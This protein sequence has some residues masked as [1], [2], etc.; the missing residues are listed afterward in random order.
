[1]T[2]LLNVKDLRAYYGQVQA[3][4]GLSFS[5]NEGSLTTLLGA[6][7]AGK[8]TTLRAICNMVRSTGA[9]EFEGKPLNNKSTESIVRFGIAHVPQ[10]RGTF[11]NMT[12][13]ENLQLGAITRSDKAGIVADIERMYSYFPKLKERH[14]QQAGTLSGG[15]QQMLA[16]ARALMLRPRL[17]LLDEPSFG[18]APL[19]VRDLFGILGKI[20]RDEKVSIL[21][22]EQNAQLALELA[23][24][25]YVIETGRIVMSGVAKDIANDEN[26]RKSYLGY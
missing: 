18:L 13:E 14:T 1:M 2:A 15:E 4:H 16:V 9:I 6:N 10:G 19:V 12:V 21:V 11:T 22:V 3:L 23:D 20:N 24:Q 26:V 5:L 17:M 7:G 25:A 8:T